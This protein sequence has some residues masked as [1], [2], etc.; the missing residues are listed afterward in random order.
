MTEYYQRTIEEE[1]DQQQTLAWLQAYAPKGSVLY[2]VHHKREDTP[3]A[4]Y[5]SIYLPVLDYRHGRKVGTLEDVS[6][7]LRVSSCVIGW[8]A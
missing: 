8:I 2:F 7:K 4:R 3:S 6:L 1:E 5:V